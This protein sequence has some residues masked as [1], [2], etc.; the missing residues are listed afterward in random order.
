MAADLRTLVDDPDQLLA[1]VPLGRNRLLRAMGVTLFGAAI[2]LLVPQRATATHQNPS[3]CW[4]AGRC[5]ECT[6]WCGCSEC[7]AHNGQCY[8]AGPH[9]HCWNVCAYGRYTRCC[10]YDS[11]TVGFCICDC[12]G[13]PC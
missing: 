11:P 9:G 13:G 5:H 7:T 4:G 8:G 1:R 2:T 6:M 3:P 12:D 10:D